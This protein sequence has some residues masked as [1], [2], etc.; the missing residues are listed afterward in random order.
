MPKHGYTDEELENLT[1][2]ERE[3]LE[4]ETLVDDPPEGEDG[5]QDANEEADAAAAAA[6]AAAAELAAKKDD[7]G[8]D[9][10]ADAAAAAAAAAKPATPAS[11]DVQPAPVAPAPTASALP[12]YKAPEN[13][14]ARLAEIE[15]QKDALA[16]KFDDG[17]L[18]A[19]E[20]RAQLKPLEDQRDDIRAQ[21]LKAELSADSQIAAWRNAVVPTFLAAHPEYKPGSIRFNALDAEVRALQASG[22]D[23][24][25]PAILAKAH[26]RIIAELG[27]AP[28]STT[29]A[30]AAK[31]NRN[32][33]PTIHN[34]PAA[35]IE[36]TE[37]GQF[38]AL[39]RLT[40]EAFEAA[41]SRMS[42][43]DQAAYLAAN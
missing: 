37:N 23:Q 13:A 41:L 34:L 28:G 20:M 18:T 9:D 8:E 16:A 11:A 1:P 32:L 27:A 35:D 15:A 33:P 43:A 39:D 26:E 36:T 31:P 4:D 25:D 21:Q 10:D 38:A 29:P 7:G 22:N 3:G 12:H 40:G 6:A 14:A 24:F 30:P 17:E 2:E 19:A 5:E 42:E